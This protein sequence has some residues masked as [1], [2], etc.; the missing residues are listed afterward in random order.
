MTE[1]KK[2]FSMGYVLRTTA[3]HMRKSVDI[4]IRKTF[5]RVAEFDGNKEKS[6]EVFQ[7]LSALHQMRKQLDDF[8]EANKDQFKG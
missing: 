1:D 5:E 3:K 6:Q 2:P 4:S 7:T 8:Q